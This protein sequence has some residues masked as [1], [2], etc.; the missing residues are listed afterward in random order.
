MTLSFFDF[1]DRA[2][3]RVNLDVDM[4]STLQCF[5]LLQHCGVVIITVNFVK[6]LVLIFVLYLPDDVFSNIG[7]LND[8]RAALLVGG[9]QI[10][11]EGLSLVRELHG[12]RI[13]TYYRVI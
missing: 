1:G 8:K 13:Y 10:D 6:L 5:I 3:C 11:F 4:W 7:L 2:R 12:S 9:C